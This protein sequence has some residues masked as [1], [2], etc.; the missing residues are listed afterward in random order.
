MAAP[1]VAVAPAATAQAQP[2]PTPIPAEVV[3][4][5]K[6]DVLVGGFGNE[7]FNA[8]YCTGECNTFGRLLHGYLATTTHQGG[9]IP[10]A[11]ESWEITDG[12]TTWLLN[13]REGIKFHDGS[14][15][16]IDDLLFS[17][18]RLTD[19]ES[20]DPEQTTTTQGAHRR[21]IASQEITGPN[22][23]TVTTHTPYA[24]FAVWNS[25]GHAGNLRMNLVP[26]KLL[27]EP[28]GPSEA[29]YE[30]LPVGA[31]PMKMLGRSPGQSMSFERFDDYY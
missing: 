17:L 23:I 29:A 6:I 30:K 13:M 20:E 14:D 27:G 9:V 10:E 15:A 12:G 2:T 19:F 28:F 18:D 3:Y 1:G 5:G 31:G 4:Q 26:R 7:R 24:G 22:E 21:L 8:R 25:N 11:L 16:T